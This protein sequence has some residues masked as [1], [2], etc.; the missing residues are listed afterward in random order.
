MKR[1]IIS[2]THTEETPEDE[3]Y[4]AMPAAQSRP[5]YREDPLLVEEDDRADMS[6]WAILGLVLLAVLILLL[7]TGGNITGGLGRSGLPTVPTNSTAR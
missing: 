6:G 4:E 7:F 3:F 5:V 2:K 1:R